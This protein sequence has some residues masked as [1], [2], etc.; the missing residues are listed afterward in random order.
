MTRFLVAAM[1]LTLLACR[2]EPDGS[3]QRG[4]GGGGGEVCVTSATCGDFASS[5]E[6]TNALYTAG[7]GALPRELTPPIEA[8]LCGSLESI[9]TTVYYVTPL[10]ADAIAAHYRS[11]LVDAGYLWTQ[12]TN[13]CQPSFAFEKPGSHGRLD[14]WASAGAYSVHYGIPEE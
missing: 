12:R 7:A 11:R 8:S 3:G 13:G 2:F 4:G 9:G 1:S 14:Q 10:D 5:A 6:R